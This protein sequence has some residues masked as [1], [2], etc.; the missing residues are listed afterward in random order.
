MRCDPVDLNPRPRTA[1]LAC[2][3][4]GCTDDAACFPTCYWVSL[5]PPLCSACEDVADDIP[6]AARAT[7]L[8][9]VQICAASSPPAQCVPLFVDDVS[10]YC[11][12]C[13]MGF[14]L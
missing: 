13:K 2:T 12:C 1:G 14:V 8:F 5:D 10:G 3:I 6:P 11:A 4:C 9:G 7:G